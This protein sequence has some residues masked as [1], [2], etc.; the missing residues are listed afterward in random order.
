M[1]NLKLFIL[2][3]AS[4]FLLMACK[5]EQSGGNVS[6]IDKCSV[7][8]TREVTE[9]GDTVVVCDLAKV[10]EKVTL[11]LSQL[12]DSLEFIRLESTDTALVGPAVLGIEV[13]KH[14]MGII[15][16]PNDNFKLF[17]RTGKYLRNIGKRGQGPGEFITIYHSHIDEKG[18]RIYLSPWYGDKILVYDLQGRY[19]GEDIPLA[20]FAHNIVINV[21]AKE[22]QLTVAQNPWDTEDI[23]AVWMQDFG[24]RVVHS[25]RMKH[26]DWQPNF[27]CMTKSQRMDPGGN[28]TDFYIQTI[29][30]R[31]DTIYHY[32]T[33]ANRCVPQFT[34]KVDERYTYAY[35]ETFHYYFVR[36]LAAGQV[37]PNNYL[38]CLLIDKSTLKGA[39][40]ELVADELGGISVPLKYN[41]LYYSSYYDFVMC[42]DPY[43]LMMLLEERLKEKDK[44]SKKDLAKITELL[45]SISDD[46]NNYLL[47]G[48]WK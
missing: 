43:R 25:Q 16:S 29:V 31:P 22:K 35:Y 26:L 37:A 7:I 44:M 48:K 40:V 21:N 15:S 19:V 42:I 23:P 47:L 3:L 28:M 4:I 32:D 38:R 14:F 45:K 9:A 13:T 12:V 20:Y 17:D 39:E 27:S 24:G 1:R 30:P 18:D 10:R 34:L 5:E 36:V 41:G 2:T 46:D 6:L 11:P 33:T 8:A